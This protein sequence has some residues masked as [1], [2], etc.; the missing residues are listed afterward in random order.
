[1]A[2]T[3]LLP[4]VALVALVASQSDT[5]FV[6]ES[7][8]YPSFHSWVL[9]Y[10]VHLKQYREALD[11][12]LEQ[13][14][15]LK[16]GI[17]LAT[18]KFE[19]GQT[20]QER[21]PEIYSP[22]VY[23]PENY[24]YAWVNEINNIT[25][26]EHEICRNEHTRLTNAFNDIILI[27]TNQELSKV[28][29][30]RRSLLPF[31]GDILSS[32]FGTVGKKD[33]RKLKRTLEAQGGQNEQ[34]VHV[35][36]ESLTLLNKTQKDVQTNREAIR[37]LSVINNQLHTDV[38]EIYNKLTFSLKSE[39]FKNTIIHRIQTIFNLVT[40]NLREAHFA[41]ITL[42]NQ[43]EAGLHGSI[44]TSL[45]TPTELQT[46]LLNIQD[47]LPPAMDLPYPPNGDGLMKYYSTLKP[48]ILPDRDGFHLVFGLPLRHLV[49]KYAIYRAVQTPVPMPNDT[50]GL[51]MTHRLEAEYIAI[52][53]N[54]QQYTLLNRADVAICFSLSVCKFHTPIFSVIDYPSC[55]ISLYLRNDLATKKYCRK[56][57]TQTTGFP[58]IQPMYGPYWL[59]TAFRPIDVTLACEEET[60]KS[61]I[62]GVTILMV[63]SGCEL[64]TEFF[65]IPAMKT[66]E[67]TIEKSVRINIEKNV[68]QTC[69]NIWGTLPNMLSDIQ[70][71]TKEI[72]LS[73]LPTIDDMPIN[74]LQNLLQ[75]AIVPKITKTTQELWLERA[76]NGS[77][78][79]STITLGIVFYYCWS[80]RNNIRSTLT[81]LF[82]HKQARYEPRVPA[83]TDARPHVDQLVISALP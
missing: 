29:R 36:S 63:P 65:H 47:H 41:S 25:K 79:T 75:N 26:R 73:G 67:T 31:V 76:V 74:N 3:K 58:K 11:L 51:A 15:K 32:L 35:V 17:V 5:Y 71:L 30:K 68:S 57:I 72:D 46:T 52:S 34:L 83:S 81:T 6:L 28:G 69:E 18:S 2:V 50:S 48:T 54:E 66:F 55:M 56:Q 12:L 14:D 9:T 22:H 38:A 44:D 27:S 10:S 49:D 13:I 21:H 61:Q 42:K 82:T 59:I 8:I 19:D 39:Y 64:I 33:L 20:L 40:S 70:P 53:H 37:H 78:S 80:R 24:T 77:I 1:M 4:L 45:I 16:D 62:K 23:S 7:S 60:S 43:L